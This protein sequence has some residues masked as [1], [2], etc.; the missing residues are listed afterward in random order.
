MKRLLIMLAAFITAAQTPNVSY[1]Q[2]NQASNT[3][4]PTADRLFYGPCLVPRDDREALPALLAL[5]IPSIIKQGLSRFGKALR[6][7]GEEKTRSFTVNRVIEDL[8]GEA[9]PC[10]QFVRGRFYDTAP[11]G[12]SLW[13]FSGAARLP[14]NNF[15]A[16][17]IYLA[18][19]PDVL[20][21]FER[22]QSKD[23]TAA[24][25]GLGFFAYRETL[26]ARRDGDRN[27]RSGSR[28]DERFLTV[29]ISF[30]AP[31]AASDSD[32]ASGGEIAI[33]RAVSGQPPR[34]FPLLGGG[35]GQKGFELETQWF[36]NPNLSEDATPGRRASYAGENDR[37]ASYDKIAWN[38]VASPL[39]RVQAGGPRAS[40]PGGDR[41]RPRPFNLT[42][43]LVEFQD[44][45]KFLTFLA[46]VFQDIEEPLG[47][48]LVAKV[49]PAARAE[50]RR[51]ELQAKNEALAKFQD[52]FV[53][54]ESAM[55]DYCAGGG[56]GRP[57]A[58]DW[59]RL[60]KEAYLAQLDANLE[61]QVLGVATPYPAPVAV[62]GN[63]PGCYTPER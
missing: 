22:R 4:S 18:D 48:A 38:S 2:G 57:D 33:G 20:L 30:H 47:D 21:E 54:A 8:P 60:S 62:S 41:A 52:K 9:Q 13:N 1:A 27:R 29:Q 58:R 37:L 14:D 53:A 11:D 55:I 49:D 61:A 45:N 43:K 7:A 16:A 12:R 32:P 31:G 63:A 46:D 56:E 42:V 24:S 5:A 28:G 25:Y 19:E 26:F 40:A 17:G 51:A 3:I 10:I 59:L 35:A 34:K 15:L 36:T 39:V 23:G 50:A 44:E 6:N